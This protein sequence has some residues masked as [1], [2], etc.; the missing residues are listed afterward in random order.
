M[1]NPKPTL[2]QLEAEL[3]PTLRD[4]RSASTLYAERQHSLLPSRLTAIGVPSPLMTWQRWTIT[5]VGMTACVVM[6]FAVILS[7]ARHPRISSSANPGNPTP[8]QTTTLSD[9]AILETVATD[10]STSVPTPL[11]RLAPPQSTSTTKVVTQ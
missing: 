3:A 4:F 6:F 1:I 9:E 7:G 2:E 5:A 11:Q 10:L 8:T